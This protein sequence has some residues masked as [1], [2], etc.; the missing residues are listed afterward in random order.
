MYLSYSNKPT[1]VAKSKVVV[2]VFPNMEISRSVCL[3]K[4]NSPKHWPFKQT[5]KRRHTGEK[6]YTCD[7]CG[8]RFAQQGNVRAHKIV[9]NQ[10]K[11]F[12]CKLDGCPKHFTQLGNL[13]VRF[14]LYFIL[15]WKLLSNFELT[16]WTRITTTSFINK[17]LLISQ[18]NLHHSKTEMS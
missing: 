14:S 18:P 4:R 10:T 11:P 6:P 12:S 15:L 17:L 7:M 3:S 9:H 2:G 5:H 16:P 13:K 1:S 8:K